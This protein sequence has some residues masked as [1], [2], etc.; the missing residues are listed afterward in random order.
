[1]LISLLLLL[2]ALLLMLLSLNLVLRVVCHDAPLREHNCLQRSAERGR[3]LRRLLATTTM[4]RHHA[5]FWITDIGAG[6]KENCAC[7]VPVMTALTIAKPMKRLLKIEAVMK[8]LMTRM[9][10]SAD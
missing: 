3:K 9:M 6:C 4:K 8:K 7:T 5:Q 1:M 10:F 2:L